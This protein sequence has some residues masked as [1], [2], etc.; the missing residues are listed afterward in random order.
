M[1]FL[2]KNLQTE[3]RTLKLK[4][5]EVSEKHGKKYR[6]EGLGH[7]FET[8]ESGILMPFCPFLRKEPTN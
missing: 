4:T 8:L 5:T 6:N 3:V 7:V 2:Y 1:P